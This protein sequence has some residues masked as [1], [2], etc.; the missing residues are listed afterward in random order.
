M[1]TGLSGLSGR[2]QSSSYLAPRNRHSY[3]ESSRMSGRPNSPPYQ[4]SKYGLPSD[5]GYNSTTGDGGYRNSNFDEDVF[6]TD[7]G[8]DRRSNPGYMGQEFDFGP[9]RSNSQRAL[10]DYSSDTG[11]GYRSNAPHTVDYSSDSGRGHVS[12]HLTDYSSDSGMSY[13]HQR[14]KSVELEMPSPVLSRKERMASANEDLFSS[15][16]KVRPSEYQRIRDNIPQASTSRHTF[17]TNNHVSAHRASP[18]DSPRNTSHDNLHLL[19]DV[20]SQSEPH[21]SISNNEHSFDHDTHNQSHE[22][23]HDL[24]RLHTHD[25]DQIQSHDHILANDNETIQSGRS[26]ANHMTSIHDTNNIDSRSHDIG[27]INSHNSSPRNNPESEESESR[28]DF[29]SPPLYRG[30]SATGE[31]PRV[32]KKPPTHKASDLTHWQQRQ[33]IQDSHIDNIDQVS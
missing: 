5:L 21:N 20:K 32:T 27:Q 13:R 3:V 19:P 14:R 9:Y 26:A 2:S 7:N 10:T 30:R 1:Q 15:P 29:M 18:P 12:R 23:L 28:L 4:P 17:E 11:G 33:R 24:D 16:V 31:Q 8:Y 22:H 6:N 25:I